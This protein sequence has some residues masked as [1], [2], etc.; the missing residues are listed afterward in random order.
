MLRR[1]CR[2]EADRHSS[3][4]RGKEVSHAGQRVTKEGV[5]MRLETLKPS[6]DGTTVQGVESGR[7]EASPLIS[8]TSRS[9][10]LTRELIPLSLIAGPNEARRDGGPGLMSESMDLKKKGVAASD[11]GPSCRMEDVG[12]YTKGPAPPIVQLS[13]KGPNCLKACTQQPD[14]GGKLR[15]GPKS[16]AAQEETGFLLKCLASSFPPEA[17]TFVAREFEDTRKLQ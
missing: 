14:L 5:S 8:P 15:E 6:D 11:A 2:N 1:K 17:E 10:A 4:V 16:S 9:W 3:E 13:I 12:C 7:V